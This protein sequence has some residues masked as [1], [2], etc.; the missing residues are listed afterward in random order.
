MLPLLRDEQIF[1][2]D[3]MLHIDA[4]GIQDWDEEGRNPSAST[5]RRRA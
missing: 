2:S 1:V 4:L 5:L 3:M